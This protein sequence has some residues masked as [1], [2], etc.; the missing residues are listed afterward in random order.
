[1]KMQYDKE[2]GILAIEFTNG[3]IFRDASL[4]WTQDKFVLIVTR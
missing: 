3:K 1:M 4:G 2:D